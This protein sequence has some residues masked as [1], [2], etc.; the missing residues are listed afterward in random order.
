MIWQTLLKAIKK[1]GY[2]GQDNDLATVKA[3]V[4]EHFGG[5]VEVE[6]KS[7]DIDGEHA[8]AF[9]TKGKL[10]LTGDTKDA[11]IADLESRLAVIL[12]S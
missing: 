4:T 11:K 5:A 6:G 9:P 1:H 7:V 2:K 10:D 3:Y 8:K 12:R